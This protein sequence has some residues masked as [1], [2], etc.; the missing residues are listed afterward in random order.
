MLRDYQAEICSK[1]E[2]ALKKER[3]RKIIP[4]MEMK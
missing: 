4:D 2:D 3:R 1:V